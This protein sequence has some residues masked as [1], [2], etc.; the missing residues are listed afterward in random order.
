MQIKNIFTKTSIISNQNK[1]TTKIQ[2]NIV[3][4]NKDKEKA[5]INK[6]NETLNNSSQETQVSSAGLALDTIYA[7][8]SQIEQ[9]FKDLS[10]QTKIYEVC[11]KVL[12]DDKVSEDDKKTLQGL[13]QDIPLSENSSECLSEDDKKMLQG[14]A[15][16]TKE[17]I[18]DHTSSDYISKQDEYIRSITPTVNKLFTSFNAET[19]INISSIS[20]KSMEQFGL[21]PSD[22]M[23]F[24]EVLKEVKNAEKNFYENVV[25]K[26]DDTM[27]KYGGVNNKDFMEKLDTESY[28]ID[29]HA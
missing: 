9:G 11:S 7:L 23:D 29:T 20:I 5:G 8:Y 1:L 12:Q 10:T 3:S 4:K 22:N 14:F 21:M 24:D 16:F 2:N 28:V 27:F 15:N 6:I 13:I 25:L 26:L 18:L 19:N 17:M